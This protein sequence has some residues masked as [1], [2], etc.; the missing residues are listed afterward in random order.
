[1]NASLDRFYQTM[2]SIDKITYT[3]LDRVL[4]RLTH[5]VKYLYYK[6]IIII[7]YLNNR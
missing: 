5:N 7:V 6:N 1:M 3:D 2:H 4:C